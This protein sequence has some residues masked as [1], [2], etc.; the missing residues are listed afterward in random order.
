MRSLTRQPSKQISCMKNFKQEEVFCCVYSKNS[1]NVSEDLEFRIFFRRSGYTP[2]MY[3]HEVPKITLNQE[4]QEKVWGKRTENNT[5]RNVFLLS[6]Y[7]MD[8]YYHFILYV[9]PSDLF[10]LFTF[11][12][13]LSCRRKGWNT[14]SYL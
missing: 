8:Y 3:R 10:L 4:K 11:V 2:S 1:Q 9:T 7:L 5:V 13:I 6:F 14:G 12:L